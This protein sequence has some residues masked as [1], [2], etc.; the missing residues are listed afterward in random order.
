MK[1][2]IVVAALCIGVN[3]SGQNGT[4]T[5]TPP[6]I[7]SSVPPIAPAGSLREGTVEVELVVDTNGNPSHIRVV[8]GVGGGLDEK[9]AEAVRQYRFKP[10]MRNGKPVSVK[11]HISV[12]FKV[13][14]KDKAPEKDDVPN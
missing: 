7:V 3:A 10:A 6:A 1:K 8:R 13:E 2:L 14:P 9:A 5:D 4:G 12:N 11:L